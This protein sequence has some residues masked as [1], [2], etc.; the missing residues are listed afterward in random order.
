M[1]RLARILIAAALLSSL[2]ILGTGLFWFLIP[3]QRAPG[4]TTFEI[5]EQATFSQVVNN[6]S[7]HNIIR[8]PILMRIYGRLLEADKHVRAGVYEF[9]EGILP[10]EV[11]DKIRKGTLILTE[12]SHPP[13][14]N[15]WQV[16]ERLEG[17]FPH[18]PQKEWVKAFHDRTVVNEFAP[19]APSLEGYLYP[20]VY[21]VRSN[22]KVNE[23]VR[24]MTANFKKNLTPEIVS[25]GKSLGLNP[26]QIVT[27]ASIVE[28]ETGASEERPLIAA[29][30]FNRMKKN[31]RLQTDPTVIY[32]IWER[33]NGNLR[34][35]DLETPTPYNT[36]TN[37]GLPPGPI[38]NPG[39]EALWAAVNPADTPFLYFV[40]KGDGT[41]YFSQSLTEHSNAVRR[42]QV[43]PNQKR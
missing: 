1:F 23:V 25:R 36:Y 38:A 6:L 43:L 34:R 24:M 10:F 35:V 39:R 20:D 11:M 15:M 31:M 2:I 29:V 7:K 37:S 32:G 21:R 41:H 17:K 42:F 12:F 4:E 18:I 16:A 27:L 5:P 33:F 28:K 3:P 19:G 13:G 8:W 9:P 26:H 22:A 30:F 14:W 40:A